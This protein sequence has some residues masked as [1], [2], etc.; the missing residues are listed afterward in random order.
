M[1]N[2]IATAAGLMH[3][4]RVSNIEL[5]KELNVTPQYVSAI[6]NGKKAPKDI[7][8]RVTTAIENI[9]SKRKQVSA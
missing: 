5:A 6:L 9:I 8:R 7:E 1:E 3:I 4:N 2:W